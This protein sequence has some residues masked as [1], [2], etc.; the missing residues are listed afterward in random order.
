MCQMVVLNS[1]IYNRQDRTRL[2]PQGP[3]GKEKQK[4]RYQVRKDKQGVGVL[5]KARRQEQR[6]REIIE[7]KARLH[8]NSDVGGETDEAEDESRR[9]DGGC[10]AVG[11]GRCRRGRSWSRDGGR[12]SCSSAG[13]LSG[14][15]LVIGCLG[16][17]THR[18]SGRAGGVGGD[19]SEDGGV[20]STGH[21]V[22]TDTS[23]SLMID[24][25]Q[26]HSRELGREGRVWV[27]RVLG[28]LEVQRGE[29]DKVVVSFIVSKTFTR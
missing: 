9:D 23:A 7:N 20:E 2:D 29:S 13:G 12:R 18:G 6:T 8:L 15:N 19:G 17:G 24:R 26:G 14:Q 3:F 16:G 10:R 5:R 4:A 25:V 21:L 28:V 1:S 11:L 22:K 27:L